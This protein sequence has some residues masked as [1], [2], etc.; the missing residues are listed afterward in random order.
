ML[1]LSRKKGES[2]ILR[3]DIEITVLDVQADT[4]KIGIRAPRDVDIVRKEIYVSV[5]ET[6]REAVSEPAVD[7]RTLRDKLKNIKNNLPEL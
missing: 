7:L 5:Q 3:D 1:V 4:V 2:I 6:N